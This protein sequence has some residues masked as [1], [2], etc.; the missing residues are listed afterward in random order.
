M[1]VLPSNLTA[2]KFLSLPLHHSG[3]FIYSHSLSLI[4]Y[5]DGT[6]ALIPHQLCLL[7]SRFID[8]ISHL[9]ISIAFHLSR[10]KTGC[11]LST[12][13]PRPAPPDVSNSVN[14]TAAT[15]VSKRKPP[16]FR[17]S[18]PPTVAPGQ[19]SVPLVLSPSRESVLQG[20]RLPIR[21][22]HALRHHQRSSAFL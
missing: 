9:V 13:I 20:L 1:S 18:S 22:V 17:S 15:Q 19:V 3:D 2:L 21:L 4:L 11:H 6:K 5:A 8:P 12:P 10:S 16:I 7:S 14:S